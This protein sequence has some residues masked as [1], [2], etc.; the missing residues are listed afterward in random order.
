[1]P[2]PRARSSFSRSLDSAAF[3]CGRVETA[4]RATM[5]SELRHILGDRLTMVGGLRRGQCLEVGA[6]GSS[7]VSLPLLSARFCYFGA[8][9]SRMQ[10][11]NTAGTHRMKNRVVL[12]SSTAS[13]E[14]G[15]FV[16]E[17]RAHILAFIVQLCCWLVR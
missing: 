16:V 5:G 2:F 14:Y 12:G 15:L 3:A 11:S 4:G 13:I 8:T 1:M 7:S 6:T 17:G 9:S 10:T